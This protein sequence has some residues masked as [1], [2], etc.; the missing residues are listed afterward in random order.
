MCTDRAVAAAGSSASPEQQKQMEKLQEFLMSAEKEGKADRPMMIKEVNGKMV[1]EEIP[2]DIMANFKFNP[3]G[4]DA[5][6]L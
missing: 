4:L 6:D 3:E 5:K 1:M 2:E